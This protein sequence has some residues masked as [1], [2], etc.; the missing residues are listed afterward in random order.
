MH[1][2]IRNIKA[3]PNYDVKYENIYQSKLVELSKKKIA[4][5]ILHNFPKGTIYL[6]VTCTGTPKIAPSKI[7]PPRLL[8][9]LTLTL[10][11]NPRKNL[12]GGLGGGGGNLPVTTCTYFRTEYVQITSD[13]KIWQLPKGSSP[14]FSSN[15]KILSSTPPEIYDFFFFS[16]LFSFFFFH[17][18]GI[19]PLVKLNLYYVSIIPDCSVSISYRIDL[20]FPWEQIFFG[21]IFITERGW[22]APILKWYEA[23]RMAIDPLQN[24]ME[25]HFER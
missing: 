1:I 14:N 23:Y 7:A 4:C 21:M 16:F 19:K 2:W 24:L 11:P 6:Y 13:N 17:I 18:E 15:I 5:P 25:T 9:T 22:N 12:L 3:K 20:L 8:R 10:T